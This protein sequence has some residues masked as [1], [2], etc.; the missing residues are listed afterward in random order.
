M[1]TYNPW[2][3]FNLQQENSIL[4]RRRAKKGRYGGVGGRERETEKGVARER[5][6]GEE[7]EKNNQ[8]M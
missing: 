1:C 6:I 7:K 5:S 4:P 8:R 2:I 3:R